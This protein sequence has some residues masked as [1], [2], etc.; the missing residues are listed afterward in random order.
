MNLGFPSGTA[1]SQLIGII[2][3][4]TSSSS[5]NPVYTITGNEIY[6][7]T[8]TGA[9]VGTGSTS[10]VQGIIIN[11]SNSAIGHNVSSNSIYNLSNTA[12]TSSA[13]QVFGIYMGGGTT[14][15]A[16]NVVSKNKI[17]DLSVASTSTTSLIQGIFTSVGL[18][19]RIYNN[20]ISLGNGLSNSP[21]IVGIDKSG[22]TVSAYHNTVRILGSPTANAVNTFAFRRTS[23]NLENI[24]SNIF[25]N[26]RSNSGTSTGKH[27]AISLQ[28]T[29]SIVLDYNDYYASGTGGVLGVLAGVDYPTLLAWQGIT[30]QDVNSKSIASYFCRPYRSPLSRFINW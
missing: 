2:A 14:T 28:A 12:V 21:I 19:L 1:G 9:N 11:G 4:N 16:I 25:I 30:F 5:Y 26:E 18:S 8:N 20:M 29:T 23:S 17:Y 13:I 7:L 22:G 3:A 6:N 27:Y 24:R 15:G 10:S